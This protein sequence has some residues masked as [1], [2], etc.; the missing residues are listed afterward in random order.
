M[1]SG[2]KLGEI[3]ISVSVSNAVVDKIKSMTQNKI[4]YNAELMRFERANPT[5]PA[6][7]VYLAEQINLAIRQ[8]AVEQ[9]S[10]AMPQISQNIVLNKKY[11]ITI[12]L[13]SQLEQAI[14]R[15]YNSLTLWTIYRNEI[16]KIKIDKK[17]LDELER[18]MSR[19]IE[20]LSQLSIDDARKQFMETFK[21]RLIN[22]L[23]GYVSRLESKVDELSERLRECSCDNDDP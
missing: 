16:P 9:L 7:Y 21:D 4:T 23:V 17:I 2:Q 11:E 19:A 6:D 3:T 18:D 12:D 8:R 10:Q 14:Q 20:Q 22:A 5:D 15:T 1:V 13:D